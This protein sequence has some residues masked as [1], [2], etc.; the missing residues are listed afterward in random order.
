MTV[1]VIP[2]NT[3]HRVLRINK[4]KKKL[5]GRGVASMMA[6]LENIAFKL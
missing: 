6:D 2:S 4:G 3:D 5:S 1:G